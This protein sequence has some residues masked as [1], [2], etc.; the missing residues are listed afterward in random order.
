MIGG[1]N[2][3]LRNSGRIPGQAKRFRRLHVGLQRSQARL[4]GSQKDNSKLK[5]ELLRLQTVTGLFVHDIRN[6]ATTLIGNHGL[7]EE[8]P[9]R[10][11]VFIPALAGGAKQLEGII[12]A[13]G[14]FMSGKDYI[15]LIEQDISRIVHSALRSS[16]TSQENASEKIGYVSLYDGIAGREKL[17]A[18][19]N[20]TAIAGRSD[21][22]ININLSV[23]EGNNQISFVNIDGQEY[24]IPFNRYLLIAVNDNGPGLPWLPKA[25]AIRQKEIVLTSD[26]YCSKSTKGEGHGQGIVSTLK[27]VEAHQG[28]L[29]V[30]NLPEGGA[31][32]K[33]YIPLKPG[34]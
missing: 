33:I 25:E 2:R 26:T 4:K 12:N 30:M 9:E 6:V 20:E 1:V 13:M 24:S 32:F 22:A 21:K 34:G 16:L 10:M 23:F 15:P 3:N 7:L 8:C 5:R 19:C 29:T 14:L 18:D 28:F 31:S 17:I 27:N 11:P